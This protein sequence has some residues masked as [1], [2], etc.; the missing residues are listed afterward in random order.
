MRINPE[1]NCVVRQLLRL[2]QALGLHLHHAHVERQVDVAV[3]GQ[4][5]ERL[6]VP[7]VSDF[8]LDQRV[9]VWSHICRTFLVDA[10]L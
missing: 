6:G 7:Q 8:Y 10:P 5:Q 4:R 1:S 2:K 3:Q 9:G